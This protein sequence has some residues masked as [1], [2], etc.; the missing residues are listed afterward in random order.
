MRKISLRKVCRQDAEELIKANTENRLYHAP[1]VQPFITQ[2]GF[3][4]WFDEQ[5]SGANIGFIARDPDTG[6]ITGVT[7]LS[8]IFMRGFQNAYLSYYGMIRFAGHGLM[9]KAVR[10]TVQA[11]F[12]D[13][14]LHR[15]EANIQ[16]ENM[17]SIAL[18]R[19]LGFRNEGFSP[20]YLRINGEWRDHERWALLRDER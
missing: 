4:T 15:L 11:A 10:L 13:V 2:E 17:K 8:Q 9:T 6:S 12:N 20:R 18:V 16:P 14:G 3:D 5:M 1:W 7:H 19:R